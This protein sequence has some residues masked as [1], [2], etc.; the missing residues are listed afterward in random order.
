MDITP[1]NA[2]ILLEWYAAMGAGEA[3]DTVPAGWFADLPAANLCLPG[4]CRRP[5]RSLGFRLAKR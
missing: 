4:R 5:S 3:I 1:H 2:G